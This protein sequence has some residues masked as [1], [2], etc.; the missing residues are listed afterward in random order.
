[1]DGGER[2]GAAEVPW[3]GGGRARRDAVDG[4]YYTHARPPDL[5]TRASVWSR[6]ARA[7]L[8]ASQVQPLPVQLGPVRPSDL[9]PACT[10]LSP[11]AVV[12]SPQGSPPIS[13]FTVLS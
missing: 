9:P 2:R 11:P 12:S 7:Q 10:S 3:D 5:R 13:E 1:M 8:G 6:V 4:A